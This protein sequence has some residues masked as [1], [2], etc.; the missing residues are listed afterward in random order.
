MNSKHFMIALS[1]RAILLIL[2]NRLGQVVI[3]VKVK[4]LHVSYRL[5]INNKT[6]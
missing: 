1:L 4:R 6:P 3:A 2:Q 5:G